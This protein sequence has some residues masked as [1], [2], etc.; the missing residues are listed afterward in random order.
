LVACGLVEKRQ[1]GSH[2]I[3]AREG[4]QRPV[5]V[6]LHARELSPGFIAALLRQ[7]EIDREEFLKHV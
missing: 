6:P 5:P 1:T 3:L 2:V 4:L 7:A